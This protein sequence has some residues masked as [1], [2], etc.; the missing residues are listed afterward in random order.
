LTLPPPPLFFD[1]PVYDE[2]FLSASM[3][4]R[5]CLQTLAAGTMALPSVSAAP[6]VAIP[7]P[8]VVFI[9]TDDQGSV[10]MNCYGA[11]DLITP[12]MDALATQ[13]V[14]FT[15]FY[16]TAPL[17][18]ASRISLLTGRH[19]QRAY[20]AGRGIHESETTMAEF[21]QEAGYRTGCFG[22]WHI[23]GPPFDPQGQGFD[24][25]IGHRV[26]AIDNYSHHTYWSSVRE[27]GLYR[28]RDRYREDGTYFP[29]IVTRESI[30]FL[31]RNR[32]RPFFLFVSFN[33]PHYPM[34]PEERFLRQYDHAEGARRTYGATVTSLDEKIGQ[35]MAA[36]DEQGLRQNTIVVLMSD[37]GHSEEP[38]GIGGSAGVFR[39]AKQSLFEGGIRV[40]CILSWPGQV[41]TGQVRQQM[42]TAMDW[43]PTLAAFCGLDTS[44]LALDGGDLGG[45]IRNNQPS[46]HAAL[47]WMLA[48]QWAVREENWKLI[49]A[50][51]RVFLADL[52][53]D[54][55]ETLNVADDQ[56]DIV[57]RLR[58]HHEAWVATGI[59]SVY[60]MR[61]SP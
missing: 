58:S 46:P 56:P 16:V 17:C 28:G 41:P 40:P 37:N 18:T 11:T 51:G 61:D 52:L 14:R 45:V 15:D 55:G 36:L 30:D 9:L 43:L 26:G 2:S 60:T 20:L 44:D 4:R 31:T 6:A 25:F 48:T 5:Q 22:K 59:E 21:F 32:E 10:D 50:E 42:G 1:F 8:N 47:H 7:K 24:E 12:H 29:D 13:G 3:T 53:S 38:E 23:G 34:Q 54:P 27:H 19:F 57:A 35:I 33:Q 39:G 49:S